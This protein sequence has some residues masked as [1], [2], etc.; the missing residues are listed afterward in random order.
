MVSR[1]AWLDYSDHER[2]KALEVI[3]LFHEEETRD[4]LGI[5]SIRDSLQI[6]SFLAQAPS[7][8]VPAISFSFPGSI[9]ISS[10][11]E[12]RITKSPSVCAGRKC[13]CWMN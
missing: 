3:D 4:E 1:L 5:G 11:I 12:S 9:L 8:R 2:R 10:R 13:D 7:K 6:S